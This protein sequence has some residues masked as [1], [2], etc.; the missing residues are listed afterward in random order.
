MKL[1]G[2]VTIDYD[3]FH[4]ISIITL[5]YWWRDKKKMFFERR[6]DGRRSLSSGATFADLE[7]FVDFLSHSFHAVPVCGLRLQYAVALLHTIIPHSK[8]EWVADL[9]LCMR[10]YRDISYT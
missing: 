2:L 10:R 5:A 7:L 6:K 8:A 9:Q 4:F 3:P 1:L